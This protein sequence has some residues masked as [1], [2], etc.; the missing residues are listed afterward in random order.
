MQ[1][2]LWKIWSTK[3]KDTW[4]TYSDL[5][6][7][8]IYHLNIQNLTSALLQVLTPIYSHLGWYKA[9]AEH[10]VSTGA[11]FILDIIRFYWTKTSFTFDLTTSPVETGNAVRV[12]CHLSWPICWPFLQKRT[13][14]PSHVIP[15][16]SIAGI[17]ACNVARTRTVC[18]P[19]S[20]W[21][22]VNRHHCNT[23]KIDF[24]CYV[25]TCADNMGSVF[26]KNDFRQRGSLQ[27]MGGNFEGRA[28]LSFYFMHLTFRP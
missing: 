28:F 7:K 10:G 12:W 2:S 8:A 20:T 16:P 13:F 24:N 26:R 19:I 11:A 25:H 1:Q 14:S 17:L 18:L 9:R 21:I 23:S 4:Y 6:W 22:W 27:T 15:E 3:F 5:M